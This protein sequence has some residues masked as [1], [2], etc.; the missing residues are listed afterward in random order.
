MLRRDPSPAVGRRRGCG[1]AREAGR[2][3]PQPVGDQRADLRAGVLLQEVPGVGD[4]VR[5][6]G[7]ERLREAP[8]GPQ[9]EHGIGVGPQDE[10]LASVLA[11]RGEHARPGLGTGRSGFGG[12]ISGKARAPALASGL[13]NGTS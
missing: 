3:S 12:R 10:L 5:D 4:H 1:R 13:G 11:Q 6:L 7:P 8:A 9:R 2:L